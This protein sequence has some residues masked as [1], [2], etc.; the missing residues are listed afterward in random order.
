MEGINKEVFVA[1]GRQEHVQFE[2]SYVIEKKHLKMASLMG[3]IVI[4]S[5]DPVDPAETE[6]SLEGEFICPFLQIG[7]TNSNGG[8]LQIIL[9]GEKDGPDEKENTSCLDNIVFAKQEVVSRSLI[10]NK[11]V[12]ARYHKQSSMI[13]PDPVPLSSSM[14][15]FENGKWNKFGIQ[16]QVLPS[17][18]VEDCFRSVV[19]SGNW[20]KKSEPGESNQD[21]RVIKLDSIETIGILVENDL[22]SRNKRFLTHTFRNVME[23][24]KFLTSHW[25]CQRI[26]SMNSVKLKK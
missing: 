22:T 1:E 21:P 5:D 10:S 17:G 19:S 11:L 8:H 6:E 3:K 20:I 9:K 7:F 4:K 25:L 14:A 16:K 26:R 2:K 13:Y 23:V 15:S 12:A 18:L 24:L